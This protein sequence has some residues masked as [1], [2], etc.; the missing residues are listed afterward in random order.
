MKQVF[1]S[2]V[3]ILLSAT[4][5]WGQP[6]SAIDQLK[7]DPRKAYGNDY[8]Y[9]LAIPRLTKAPSGY[10]PFYIS[11]YARHG[12]RYYWSSSLYKELDTLL[13]TAHQ[14]QL[15]TPVGETFRQKFMA[16]KQE[17]QTGVSELTELGWQQ[18]QGIARIMYNNFPEVFKKGGNVLA[19]SS[20]VGRCVLSMSAFCQELVQCNPKL[21]IREQSSRFTLDAVVPTDGQ[22]PVKH[23]YP[24]YVKPRYEKN[25]KNF[26]REHG[27]RDKIAKRMFVSTEGLPGNI[28][29]I[30]S[31]LINLYT[32]L[33]SIGHEGMMEGIVSDEEIASEWE[34]G[35]LGAYSW[36]FG[37]QYQMI[38]I[39]QDIL[40]KASAAI[41]GSSDH[42]ADLRFGHDT[43]IGP[44][45]V[46]MG[47]NGAD[48]DPEDP[49]EV[50]NIYQNWETCKASNIQLI[51]YRS[52]KPGADTLVK[53]L[54]NGN[55]A[56]L[57]VPTQSYPYYK[58]SDFLQFYTQRCNK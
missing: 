10:K 6:T 58:W 31:N 54:L 24:R 41:D 42:V 30:T 4:A 20:L 37:P 22:N 27:L 19:I 11:H 18:H 53:C 21:E 29:H 13:T 26:K 1:F 38:P 39:L 32:S 7:A 51:F 52:N 5:V 56:K 14:K 17:L 44:L 47:I 50:K 43:C 35:N 48:L 15:L 8:P 49:Y 57:P 40:Q 34:G 12:S 3:F 23:N 36:V 55:E 16:A 45:T 46:L 33:P 25:M 2:V 28:H 9:Q